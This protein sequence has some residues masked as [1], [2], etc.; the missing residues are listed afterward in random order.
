V[1]GG[2]NNSTFI[3]TTERFNPATGSFQAGPPLDTSRNQH[4]ATLLSNGTV[5]IAGGN[6]SAGF[7]ATAE[8]FNP[9][10]GTFAPTG[11]M[12]NA[13]RQH[14]AT[15]LSNGNVLVAGGFDGTGILSAADIYDPA[16]GAFA[17]TGSMA[18]PRIDHTASLLPSGNVLI[19]GGTSTEENGTLNT[20]VGVAE[21]YDPASGT[22]S[23]T[24]TMIT[25]RF[26]HTATVLSS[27]QV[28]IAGGDTQMTATSNSPTASIEIYDP[29]SGTFTDGGTLNT[30]RFYHTATLIGGKILFAGGFGG[31]GSLSAPLN[32]AELYDLTT[33]T[34]TPIS[35]M[36]SPRAFFTATPLQ[37]GQI[38]VVG[39]ADGS[40]AG[41]AGVAASAEI[42]K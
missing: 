42:F 3:Q 19:A 6:G 35:N 13:R 33:H 1:T 22:F 28:V 4:T 12:S 29:A 7:F 15:L 5:L 16:A 30:A 8:V 25:P 11:S 21:L 17:P 10:A 39:G 31:T 14:T 23:S 36:V 40:G 32:S 24:G 41:G 37:N 2:F 26:G 34:S 27:G 18:S 20:G 38:L 9:S